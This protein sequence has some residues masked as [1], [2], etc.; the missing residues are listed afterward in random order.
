VCVRD[1]IYRVST[2]QK[3]QNN[4]PPIQLKSQNGRNTPS[5]QTFTF[6]HRSRN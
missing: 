3:K 4:H 2:A 1:A 6:L 5:D